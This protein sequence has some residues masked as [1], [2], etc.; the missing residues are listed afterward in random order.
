MF[1]EFHARTRCIVCGGPIEYRRFS[2]VRVNKH[3][4][5]ETSMAM[6]FADVRCC[7]CG[8]PNDQFYT[9]PPRLRLAP[10]D[11]EKVAAYRTKK[12]WAA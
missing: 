12:G 5:R 11:A 8:F 9:V 7:E 3:T 6:C 10:A 1:V 4:M 2:T